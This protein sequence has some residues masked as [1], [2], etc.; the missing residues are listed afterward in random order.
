[1]V[2]L[3][4]LGSIAFA[5]QPPPPCHPNP[6]ATQD[7]ATVANRG[8][9]RNLP[10]PLKN[11]LVQMAGRPH[12]YL[13]M[14]ANAEAPSPSQLFQYYMLDPKG[15][16]PNVFTSRIPGLNETAMLT[17][18]GANCELPDI[19]TIRVVLEPK[20]GLP[21]D[22]SDPGAFIDMFTDISYLSVINNESGWYEGWII[23]DLT[24]APVNAELR[25]DGHTQFGMITSEDAEALAEMG[26]GHNVPGAIFTTDGQAVP[27]PS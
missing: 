13:P 17:V 21:T 16:E 19:G 18:T 22:P 25:P 8:D 4:V 20:P 5:D 2:L 12:T 7:M 27:F 11:R 24:V 1:F 23:H 10:T 14:Q 9:I 3:T 15:F 26:T 6:N